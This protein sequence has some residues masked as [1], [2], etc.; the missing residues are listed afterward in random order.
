MAEQR[1]AQPAP[2]KPMG[3]GA[4]L[5]GKPK[6]A[7]LQKPTAE[8]VEAIKKPPALATEIAPQ[9]F[10]GD[11]PQKEE[12]AA[13]AA[14][15]FVQPVALPVRAVEP[16]A[17][18]LRYATTVAPKRK[19]KRADF[20]RP[21]FKEKD[22]DIAE[23]DDFDDL[24]P[25]EFLDYQA[26]QAA[27]EETDPYLTKTL[28]YTPQ[29]RKSFYR[30]VNKNYSDVFRLLPQVKGRIDEEACAKLEQKAGAAVESFLY[31]KFVRE[32][33]RN[34]A[35][36]RGMLVYH[37][38]GSGKTCSAIAAAEALYGTSDKKIVVMTPFS[39]RG[40]F[41]SEISFCGFRHFSLTNHWVELS[42]DLDRRDVNETEELEII[43]AYG[44]S[45]LSLTDTYLRRVRMRQP[46][47]RR[48]LWVPDFTKPPNDTTLTPQQRDDIREQLTA[49]IE[50]RI[51]FISYNGITASKL[52]EYACNVDPVTGKRFFDD[53][54]IVIDEIHNLTRLMQGEVT[55]YIVSR[56]GRKRKVAAEPIVPGRWVPSLCNK[57][58]NYKR[59][60]LFYRLLTDARQSKIIGLSGTPIINFPEEL[61]ILANVLAGYTECVEFTLR[62]SDPSIIKRVREIAEVEERVDIVRFR[63]ANQQMSVLISVFP[64]GYTRVTDNTDSFIGVQYDE[65]ATDGI[66]KVYESIKAN[67]LKE[68]IPI[69]EE[70]FVSYPRLPIDGEEFRQEFI[71]PTSLTI[72]N[73]VVLQKRL[74]GLISYYKGS[75]EEYMQPRAERNCLCPSPDYRRASSSSIAS[76]TSLDARRVSDLSSL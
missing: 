28:L 41:M 32:Y 37:G 4:L 17:T 7:Q 61:G 44:R 53:A 19:P 42:I 45:V 46:A 11:P 3:V 12:P 54:V 39:L 40:N 18:T 31:Q 69:G 14:Y 27:I 73:R 23:Q 68:S 72:Q 55:P 8:M 36:Y 22:R 51:T 66:Q 70:T 25:Q 59:A 67:L 10:Y 56:K 26:K 30:F 5:R 63:A 9:P 35:P 1:A 33:I 76:R 24:L 38:L 29:S 74:T 62:S 47:S 58:M 20:T 50:S 16:A 34:A 15:S 48:V 60:Y 6:P 13:A 2:K 65:D 43:L 64:E 52:K 49:T 57:P 21:D 71:H 75:K